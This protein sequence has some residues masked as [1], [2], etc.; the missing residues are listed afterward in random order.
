MRKFIF[1]FSVLVTALVFSACS[2]KKD[3]APNAGNKGYALDWSRF[4]LKG[5]VKEYEVTKYYEAH[6][7]SQKETIIHGYPHNKAVY[8]FNEDGGLTGI[9]MYAFSSA[10]GGQ[11][12]QIPVSL[13]KYIYDDS[14]RVQQTETYN[15]KNESDSILVRKEIYKYDE[16][17]GR[18]VVNYYV[19]EN[20]TSP[21][22]EYS[23][24]LESG[25]NG[26]IINAYP[27]Q[28]R[29]EELR[30]VR[31][32]FVNDS[33]KFVPAVNHESIL[34]YDSN[35]NIVESAELERSSG[36]KENTPDIKV[37]ALEK[38]SITY[39]DEPAGEGKTT[40]QENIAD[41]AFF[42][43]ILSDKRGEVKAITIDDYSGA[44]NE[45]SGIDTLADIPGER[46]IYKFNK[47]GIN[48]GMEIWKVYSANE[49]GSGKL[50]LML[51]EEYG[52]D[53]KYRRVSRSTIRHIRSTDGTEIENK[54]EKETIN[55]N[56]GEKEA[57]RVVNT[58][59]SENNAE[60]QFEYK[61]ALNDEGY[62]IKTGRSSP[63]PI[64][65]SEKDPLEDAANNE[66]W[67]KSFY[68]ETD[69]KGQWSKRRL[70]YTIYDST[71]NVKDKI[72]TEYKIRSITYY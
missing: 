25:N 33:G 59:Y 16:E 37:R 9:R 43:Y 30:L 66:S 40:K 42:P 63:S 17:D 65:G 18:A 19:K 64:S 54:T 44:G 56:A 51:E 38:K 62:I 11:V 46:K 70:S 67:Y 60:Q 15:Y 58:T 29:G 2:G 13:S 45:G 6:W 27:S 26:N 68:E 53:A 21:A 12:S 48:T 1:I 31:G 4:G 22:R 3:T 14:K 52:Y 55:Y 57:L 49:G 28:M 8:S 23:L 20:S 35:G 5:K 36:D 47:K 69:S 24:L 72:V 7:D 10:S 34:T 39:Y 71:R 41:A 50:L 61:H 32:S